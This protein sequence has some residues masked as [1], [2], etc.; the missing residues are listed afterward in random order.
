MKFRSFTLKTQK[1][2][3]DFIRIRIQFLEDSQSESEIQKINSEHFESCQEY[4]NLP[5]PNRNL[6]FETFQSIFSE[7]KINDPESV[8]SGQKFM[9]NLTQHQKIE[10]IDISAIKANHD[11]WDAHD[12]IIS[13]IPHLLK[14]FFYE[15]SRFD[16]FLK[17]ASVSKYMESFIKESKFFILLIKNLCFYFENSPETLQGLKT[18]FEKN[19][20]TTNF[21]Q[22]Q[23]LLESKNEIINN[24]L[25][26]FTGFLILLF[27]KYK[28][29]YKRD[30]TDLRIETHLQK[31]PP[32]IK[33]TDPRQK[34][35]GTE[36]QNIANL[37]LSGLSFEEIFNV[38]N[39][40]KLENKKINFELRE[41]T[42]PFL[43]KN[44]LIAN[45][46]ACLSR[47]ITDL[48]SLTFFCKDT[49]R[50]WAYL[51]LI[52]HLV[53]YTSESDLRLN[54]HSSCVGRMTMMTKYL[55]ETPSTQFL[56]FILSNLA[57]EKVS[58]SNY[59]KVLSYLQMLKF[60]MKSLLRLEFNEKLLAFQK[61]LSF[62]IDV[63][64]HSSSNPHVYILL[65]NFFADILKYSKKNLFRG[66]KFIF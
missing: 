13:S 38:F 53:E 50:S 16:G 65:E 21:N 44:F 32:Q 18:T 30:I 51:K 62:M 34:N 6:K 11:W 40:G 23:P 2:F 31:G 39:S 8:T 42:D 29:S 52:N 45:Q 48:V 57:P 4:L 10:K 12:L 26:D 24:F 49:T 33:K 19:L 5:N 27:Q 3:N 36:L 59:W 22:P 14:W 28:K 60:S 47:I 17:G 25:M 64:H 54:L 9:L 58:I 66:I 43:V 1:N 41:N 46:N 15:K 37:F 35:F 56:K 55:L 20:F 7:Y 61:I 63:I